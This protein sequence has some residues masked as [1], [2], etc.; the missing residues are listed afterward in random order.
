MIATNAKTGES[1]SGTIPSTGVLTLI[2]HSEGQWTI[3]ATKSGSELSR[4]TIEIPNRLV[5]SRLPIPVRIDV[6][7]I[8]PLTIR[9]TTHGACSADNVYVIVGGGSIYGGGT[10]NSAECY[11]IDLTHGAAPNICNTRHYPFSASIGKYGL[12]MSGRR[13][14]TEGGAYVDGNIDIFKVV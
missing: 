10:T 7:G 2:L 11:G 13:T 6:S 4:K 3:V 8:S 5:M 12:L 14:T 9:R 1:Q